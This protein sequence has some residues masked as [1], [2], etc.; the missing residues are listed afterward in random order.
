MNGSVKY[1]IVPKTPLT[2]KGTMPRADV[3]IQFRY[4]P[5]TKD[6][7]T[8]QNKY[9]QYDTFQQT[10]TW[11]KV[12]NKYYYN[13]PGSFIK[14]GHTYDRINNNTLS[15]IQGYEGL[16]HTFPYVL[17]RN[18]TVNYY[19]NRTGQKIQATKTY[20]PHQGDHWAETHPT[21]TTVKNGKT[22]TYRYVKETGS[23]QSGTVGTSNITI[24]YYYDLPLMQIGVK[25]LQI[26]TAPEE[27]GLPVKVALD[28]LYN[29][30]TTIADMSSKT[31]NVSLYQ[32]STRLAMN[33]YVANKNEKAVINREIER[34]LIV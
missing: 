34:L 15:G 12:G 33:Q 19:D 8:W 2:Q 30:G 14:N 24:N 22:Y 16:T 20:T 11:V 23:A 26:F 13:Q 10:N 18:V 17:R 28:R 1:N 9:H 6:V 3:Y 29:Y 32:G 25:D 7:V 27:N 31:I 5:Y 21:N 4:D